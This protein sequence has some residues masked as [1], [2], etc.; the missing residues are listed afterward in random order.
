MPDQESTPS[1][2]LRP[3]SSRRREK[4]QLSCTA[5]RRRT[6]KC[7]RQLLCSQCSMCAYP[8][9]PNPTIRSQPGPSSRPHEPGATQIHDRVNQLEDLVL[10]LM[11]QA[12]TT[13]A[14]L[15]LNLS[16]CQSYS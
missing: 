16:H 2:E 13:P 15:K 4:T 7:D 6:I 3:P 10:N 11:Q 1:D 14:S 9:N 5:C 8:T 12:Q